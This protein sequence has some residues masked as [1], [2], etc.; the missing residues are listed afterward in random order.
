[1]RS[2][3]LVSRFLLASA[4]LALPTMAAAAPPIAYATESG[5]K[6]DLYLINPNGSGKV[7][8]YSSPN[9]SN[10]GL[11]DMDPTSNRL[12]VTERGPGVSRSSPTMRPAFASP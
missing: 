10:I 4:S 9:K 7:L 6:L 3:T 5:S 1:M 2:A 11:I 12:V 8:L